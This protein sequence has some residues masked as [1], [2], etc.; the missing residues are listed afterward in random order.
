MTFEVMSPR[1]QSDQRANNLQPKLK[2]LGVVLTTVDTA[3][4]EVGRGECTEAIGDAYANGAVGHEKTSL[5]F[6][7]FGKNGARWDL[8]LRAFGPLNRVCGD[9]SAT[10][11]SRDSLKQPTKFQKNESVTN[12][13]VYVRH[14]SGGILRHSACR[15]P[16]SR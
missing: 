6:L 8:S 16:N 10:L 15:P 14:R 5:L 7:P 11:L 9:N 1:S 3:E 4:Q 13:G 2:Q 12:V